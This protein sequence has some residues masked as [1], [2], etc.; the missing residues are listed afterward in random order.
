MSNLDMLKMIMMVDALRKKAE[1][2]TL[3]QPFSVDEYGNVIDATG[4]VVYEA[5]SMASGDAEIIVML[6]NALGFIDFSDMETFIEMV[7]PKR[8]GEADGR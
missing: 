3:L 8:K 7:N 5:D 4:D 2:Y 1:R 6:Y